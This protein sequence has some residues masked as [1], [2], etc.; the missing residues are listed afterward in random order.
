M[1]SKSFPSFQSV[2][3]YSNTVVIRIRYPPSFEKPS[4]RNINI[5]TLDLPAS[6]L[7]T[8]CTI[9][10]NLFCATLY[11]TSSAIASYPFP[12]FHFYESLV[13]GRVESEEL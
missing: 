12:L 11:L 4:I 13:N 8:P 5:I 9:H 7:N 3:N 2:F 10:S 6:H 1:C